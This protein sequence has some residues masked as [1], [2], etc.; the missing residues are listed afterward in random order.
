MADMSW[1]QRAIGA[2]AGAGVIALI[3]SYLAGTGTGGTVVVAFAT[4]LVCGGAVAFGGIRVDRALAA[5]TRRLAAAADGDLSSPTPGAVGAAM[6][7]LSDALDSLFAEVRANLDSVHILASY[8]AVTALANRTHFRHE[9]ERLMR[10]LPPDAV[11]ALLF[12]DLDHFKS[13]NDSLG[14]AIGDQLL[15]RVGG[16]LRQVMGDRIG[17]RPGGEPLIGR[18]SGDEFTI[19]L[20]ELRGRGEADRIAR[21]ALGTLTEPFEI[22]GNAIRIGASIGVALRPDH[23]PSLTQLMRA[24]DVAMY[25]AK[26]TGRGCVQVYSAVLAER[27]ADKLRLEQ[28]LR[29]AIEAGQFTLV[30]QPQV[31]FAGTE[32]VGAEALLR[33]QH[34]TEGIK[35]PGD[36]LRS[37]ESCGLI[38]EI[39]DWVIDAVAATVARWHGLGLDQRLAVNISA[40][41]IER[42]DF[43]VRLRRTMADRGAPLRLLTLEIGEDLAM[44]CGETVIRQLAAFRADGAQIAIDNFG[45][46]ASNLGRLKAL[47][48]DLVKLDRSLIAD[49]DHATDARMTVHAVIALLHSLGKRVVAEGVETQGQRGVLQAIGCDRIQGYAVAAPMG[50][51]DFLA[52]IRAERLALAG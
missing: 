5:A 35:Q 8:D 40:R 33:W 47:P 7:K 25:Q 6:P 3:L 12:I 13:V 14:H 16:R 9:A 26:Q 38:V 20:P 41:E 48:V 18:L 29:V 11:S 42:P 51:A 21:A 50:E 2:A 19:F 15:K 4:A 10:D 37:A 22:A 44:Q 32:T 1:R 36:F 30:F 49:V 23:G 46:G 39:G 34:P 17:D 28:A 31:A 45:T 43:F 24:A 52:W 27:L